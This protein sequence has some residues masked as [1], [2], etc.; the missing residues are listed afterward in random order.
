VKKSIEFITG[1]IQAGLKLVQEFWDE[2]GDE[3]IAIVTALWENIKAVID[4]VLGII[5]TVFDAF[6]LAFQGDWRGFGEKLREAW[7]KAWELI[8]NIIRNAW[9]NWKVLVQILITKFIDF[10]KNTDWKQV[11]IDIIHGIANGIT[12][13]ASFIQNIIRNVL[14]AAIDAAKG[15]LGIESPS[16]VFTKIGKLAGLGFAVGLQDD[17]SIQDAIKNILMGVRDVP[18]YS[19]VNSGYRFTNFGGMN[20]YGVQDRQ[21]FLDDLVVGP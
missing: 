14:Q 8:T 15:F 9:D 10:I 5:R 4:T 17:T 11:G 1:V 3:I 18:L 6:S 19:T 20:I 2:H 12:A 21:S 16:K 13:A 7:D